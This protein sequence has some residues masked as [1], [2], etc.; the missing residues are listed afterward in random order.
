ADAEQAGVRLMDLP[1]LHEATMRKV[2]HQAA[3]FWAA[4]NSRDGLG[5]MDRQRVRVWLRK[6]YLP[7]DQMA[8]A[9]FVAPAAPEEAP[10][11]MSQG[12][13]PAF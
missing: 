6:A 1:A 3:S 7:L 11:A 10:A 4:A 5:L 2:D 9:L 12:Y 13:D 8:S